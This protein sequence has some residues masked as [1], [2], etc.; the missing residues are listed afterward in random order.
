MALGD[1]CAVVAA[2]TLANTSTSARATALWM[3]RKFDDSLHGRLM[4]AATSTAQVGPRSGERLPGARGVVS[5]AGKAH[6]PLRI[7]PTPP[8]PHRH[9]TPMVPTTRTSLS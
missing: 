8:S 1:S 6:V 4:A 2:I 9:Q 3:A 7:T 5:E